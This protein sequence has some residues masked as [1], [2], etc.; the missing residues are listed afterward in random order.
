MKKERMFF[1]TALA[2][3]LL[4]FSGLYSC[5]D[6][7]TIEEP[8]T[9]ESEPSE[10]PEPPLS[11]PTI[12]EDLKGTIWKLSGIVDVET[13][14]LTELE[15]KD[16]E[17]CYTIE[18][19]ISNTIEFGIDNIIFLYSTVNVGLISMTDIIDSH[20]P[21]T[22]WRTDVL[23]PLDGE[24]YLKIHMYITSY[25][26][27]D[28][29]LKFFYQID[30]KE[31]YLLYK[32]VS[33]PDL[34]G[35]KWKLAGLMDVKTGELTE[36]E[37]KDCEECYTLEFDSD[38]RAHGISVMN[39]LKLRLWPRISHATQSEAL[40]YEIGDTPLFYDAWERVTSYKAEENE[41]W[42]VYYNKQNYLLYK[43]IQP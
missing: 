7:P 23:D 9:E 22:I 16:C 24:L 25:I 34:K 14:V 20:I 31:S 43:R 11:E 15:P 19:N 40:D 28:N 32:P 8:K 4:L 41:L 42:F 38:S 26:R 33:L 37:P 30:G 18:F 27:E 36:L 1:I 2:A 29:E 17:E 5:N 10:E 39:H 35:T 3:A 6:K 21:N 12:P 13:G